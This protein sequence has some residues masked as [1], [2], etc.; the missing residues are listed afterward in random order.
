MRAE[1]VRRAASGHEDTGCVAMPAGEAA[2]DR[3]AQTRRAAPASHNRAMQLR[4][5]KMHGAGNDVIVLD[6][7]RA[8]IH[9]TAAQ[10]GW[11]VD[12][13]YGV[14]ADQILVVGPPDAWDVDFSY[15]IYNGSGEEVEHCG[16]GA[17]CFM[18]YLLATGMTDRREIRVST[19]NRRLRLT[20]QDDGDIAV[21]MGAPELDP[22]RVPFS[23]AGSPSRRVGEATVWS[24]VAE[25]ASVEFV[26]ASMGNPHAVIRVPDVDAAPVATLGAAI[27][28]H[29][30]FPRR[31]NVGFV[32]V[33]DRGHVRLRVYERGVGETLAC[34]TGACAAV[35]ACVLRGEV[36][37]RVQVD[38]RG[39][40]LGIAWQGDS[41]VM[42]GPATIVFQ[43]EITL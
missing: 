2:A 11:L 34:G 20:V 43:G 12:R 1:G 14:G 39:G 32:Q 13:R 7:T 8:P 33:V 29:A 30:A 41:V 16:N 4:F 17:R 9:L 6:A 24:L 26:V 27:E 19:L 23:T 37:R 5:T 42:T 36:D 10:I 15:R 40:R 28:R 35:V 3:P 22:A 38:A 21:D 25:G 18:R 31:V